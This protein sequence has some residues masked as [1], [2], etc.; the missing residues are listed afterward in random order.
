MIALWRRRPLAFAGA[1]VAILTAW[2][3]SALATSNLELFFDEAQYWF[4]SLDPAFGYFSKP[5]MVAWLIAL[6]TGLFGQSEFAVRVTAPLCYAI[7]AALAG[8]IA[9]TVFSDAPYRRQAT[10][11]SAITVATLPAVSVSAQLAST[12]VP[13]L[14]FWSASV[15]CLLQY[16]RNGGWWWIGFG[17]AFGAGMMS[18]YAMAYLLLC[19]AIA[20]VL[21]PEVRS[22]LRRSGFWLG[23]TLGF[24]LFLPNIWWNWTHQLASFSHTAANAHWDGGL[25]KPNKLA[26]FAGAQ[27][28]IMGPILLAAF[29]WSVVSFRKLQTS[30]RLL[31]ALS[32][33]VLVLMLCQALLSRAHANWAAVTYI[34]ATVLTVAWLLR[35]KQERWLGRSLALHGVALAAILYGAQLA[36]HVGVDP[37]HRMRGWRAV[38]QEVATRLADRPGALL[39]V[40]DRAGMAALLFYVPPSPPSWIKLGDT[41]SAASDHYELT[42]AATEIGSRPVLYLSRW[43]EADQV[44]AGLAA[45]FTKVEP[46]PSIDRQRPTRPPQVYHAFWLSG[47]KG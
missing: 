46:S 6:G 9:W 44:P 29:A 41:D 36:P 32:L 42:S 33:P 35:H 47:F 27:F 34:A 45:R 4:W 8:G 26:E 1:F 43:G 38:G 31:V 39:M 30:E 28:G 20:F 37:W 12:D 10:A 23:L 17:I 11:W 5:P 13:L 22:L 40:S 3:L 14:L 2:R 7:T 21:V 19:L 25:F 24:L 18:K 16:W 15:L